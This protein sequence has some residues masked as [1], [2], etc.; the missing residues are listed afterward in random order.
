MKKKTLI[1]IGLMVSMLASTATAFAGTAGTSEYIINENGQQEWVKGNIAGN[2]STCGTYTKSTVKEYMVA[3]GN[4]GTMVT[5][6]EDPEVTGSHNGKMYIIVYND[7]AREYIRNGKTSHIIEP[8]TTTDPTTSTGNTGNSENTGNTSGGVTIKDGINVK[9][10]PTQAELKAY[11]KAHP[12]TDNK[13]NWD[14]VTY[15]V[16][17]DP[18][19]GVIGE[20]SKKTKEQY[21]NY[22]NLARICAGMPEVTFNEDSSDRAQHAAALSYLADKNGH[23]EGHN[24]V[25]R[26]AGLT[27][28]Q[29]EIG[30]EACNSSSLYSITSYKTIHQILAGFL[31]EQGA[32]TIGHRLSTL[33]NAKSLGIGYVN[34]AAAEMKGM[35]PCGKYEINDT[36]D[37][38]NNEYWTFPSKDFPIELIQAGNKFNSSKSSYYTWSITLGDNYSIPDKNNLKVVFNHSK[39]GSQT[40]NYSYGTADGV[41]HESCK[42]VYFV[43]N[44]GKGNYYDIG[45]KIT[46]TLTGIEKNGQSATIKYTTTLFSVLGYTSTRVEDNED[47]PTTTEPTTP[48]ISK[49]KPTPAKVTGL[50]AKAGRKYM[51]VSW[52]KAKNASGYQVAYAANKSF[53]SA[54]N[55]TTSKTTAK[56]KKLKSKKTYYVK[57]R[58]YRKS[59]GVMY[60]GSYS[61]IVKKKIK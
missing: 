57:V 3:Q 50:K 23:F 22:V 55:M 53:K 48:S 45:D 21:L 42:V 10:C 26:P 19:N 12:F 27:D 15:S 17:P 7:G 58:A 18:E 14:K 9:P 34:G 11:V 37:I 47:D 44:L 56:L 4:D 31:R 5:V 43:P 25:T 49:P 30:K 46:V 6:K 52:K 33:S 59:G 51:T 20:L 2:G 54:K 29:W 32:G 40:L 28:K 61:N 13:V 38:V 39:Y 35:I 36:V 8:S 41:V 60:Y 1:A 24:P 16:K